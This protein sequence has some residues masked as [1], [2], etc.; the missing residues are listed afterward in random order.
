MPQA[1]AGLRGLR[2]RAAMELRQVR[3]AE[4]AVREELRVETASHAEVCA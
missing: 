1:E 3:V 2:T 4:K